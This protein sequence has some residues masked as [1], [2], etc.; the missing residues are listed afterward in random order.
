MA[1]TYIDTV[2]FANPSDDNSV[3]LS[4]TAQFGDLLT[5][6]I[7]YRKMT[8]GVVSNVMW[9]G[10]PLTAYGA[11][12]DDGEA[13]TVT[14]W[15]QVFSNATANL[16]A[17]ISQFVLYTAT[18]RVDRP[19]ASATITLGDIQSQVYTSGTYANPSLGVLTVPAG[20]VVISHLKY[21]GWDQG[22]GSITPV[23]TA[24]SPLSDADG[25]VNLNYRGVWG[26][27][28]AGSLAATG[29]VTAAWAQDVLNPNPQYAHRAAAFHATAAPTATIDTLTTDGNTGLVV[30]Q[31][32]AMTTTNLGTITG[33]TITTAATPTATTDAIN[34]ALPSGDG[35]GEMKDWVDAEFYA[36]PGTVIVEA[37]D[38]VDTASGSYTLSMPDDTVNVI[39]A[40]VETTDNT[41]IGT[42]LNDIGHPLEDDDIGYY[43]TG[44]GLAIGTNSHV[45]CLGAMVFVLWIQKL[46]GVMEMY[47]VTIN[48]AGEITDVTGITS[49]GITSRGITSRNITSRGLS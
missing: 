12:I 19:P 47:N 35:A 6:A 8:V 27:S 30:G 31:P 37:T 38:G 1:F 11:A 5:F 26:L 9:N 44:N 46:D 45:S 48:D 29:T 20:A 32:F 43:P 23:F 3:S 41:Y 22:Y 39:F 34:L 21:M 40:D 28:V 4:V 15:A 10:E 24:N 18:A 36:Y 49:R 17:S 33:I 13:L 2:A 14:Y 25:A 16:T 42:K 7:T